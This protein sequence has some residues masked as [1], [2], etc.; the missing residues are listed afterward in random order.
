MAAGTNDGIL[1]HAIGQHFR[2][3][4]NPTIA[5]HTVRANL[6]IGGN[7]NSTFKDHID[8]NTDIL[9]T[10]Q[11]TPHIHPAGSARVT[12]P[13]IRASACCLRNQRPSP[14]SW[15][16]LFHPLPSRS[17]WGCPARTAPP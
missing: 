5:D 13:P 17:L 8:V 10:A 11:L 15:L 4:F 9:T 14:T 7:L 12:P 6:D 3:R 16:P 2:T 1:N